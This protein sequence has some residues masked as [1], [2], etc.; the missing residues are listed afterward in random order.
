MPKGA[1]AYRF[2]FDLLDRELTD[3]CSYGA[4]P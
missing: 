2:A 3:A 1:L 4:I